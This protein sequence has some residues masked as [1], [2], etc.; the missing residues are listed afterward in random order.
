M[1]I[2]GP[3]D[4]VDVSGPQT[5]LAGRRAGEIELDLPQK[6]VLALI[7]PRRREKNRWI[8]SRY[9]HIAGLAMVPLGLKERQVLFSQLICFHSS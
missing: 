2:G 7:H 9:Q 3:T 8:P 6:M 4:V 5:L 1:V